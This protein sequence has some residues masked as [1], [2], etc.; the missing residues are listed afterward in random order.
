MREVGRIE[1]YKGRRP[2]APIIGRQAAALL[3][4][5]GFLV[6]ACGSRLP[7]AVAPRVLTMTLPGPQIMT[8]T[9]VDRTA[10]LQGVSFVLPDPT[11]FKAEKQAIAVKNEGGDPTR[12]LVSWVGGACSPTKA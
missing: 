8:V 3:A 5:V 7:L 11:D 9:I 1:R 2:C 10:L 6:A 12:L 4:A